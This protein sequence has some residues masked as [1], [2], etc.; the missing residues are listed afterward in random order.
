MWSQEI[1][2]L[3]TNRLAPLRRHE[4]FLYDTAHLHSLPDDKHS[5]VP[6]HVTG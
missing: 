4:H 6:E 3:E 2:Y 1:R 5:M